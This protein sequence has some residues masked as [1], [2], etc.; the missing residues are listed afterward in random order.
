MSAEKIRVM[1]LS[2]GL[3]LAASGC[4]TVE[5]R[6][7]ARSYFG[8]LPAQP[9]ESARAFEHSGMKNWFL[10]GLFAYTDFSSGSLISTGGPVTRIEGIEL[11]TEFDTIDNI[12]WVI[13][14]Q[15]Y[16]YYFWAPRHVSI[17][18]REIRGR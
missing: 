1:G 4:F 5:H 7:P 14:G 9:G 11:G 3:A 10:A 8:R 2:L 13:P 15:V 12:A 6:L 16:G 17:R 18:G